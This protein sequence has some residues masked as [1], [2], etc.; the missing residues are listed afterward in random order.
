[1]REFGPLPVYDDTT[2]D[3]SKLNV[4][5]VSDELFRGAFKDTSYIDDGPKNDSIEKGSPVKMKI[6]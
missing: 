6:I 5:K 1:M 3:L 4:S 2:N